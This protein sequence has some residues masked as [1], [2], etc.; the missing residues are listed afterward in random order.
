MSIR[1]TVNEIEVI[2]GAAQAPSLIHGCYLLREW[3]A[4]S[5]EW[6]RMAALQWVANSAEIADH[7]ST[8]GDHI[9]ALAMEIV[10][11]PKK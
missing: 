1:E 6:A 7:C 2:E 11:G 8:T 10:A 3:A 4:Q 9:H 5:P